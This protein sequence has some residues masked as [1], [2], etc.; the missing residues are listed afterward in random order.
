MIHTLLSEYFKEY[1]FAFACLPSPELGG[2]CVIGAAH[3]IST[4]EELWSKHNRQ[5]TSLFGLNYQHLH[6][7]H[8]IHQL[9]HPFIKP[10]SSFGILPELIKEVHLA[11]QKVNQYTY[12]TYSQESPPEKYNN[13]IETIK[14]EIQAGEY[15]EINFCNEWIGDADFQD[16]VQTFLDLYPKANVPYSCLVKLDKHWLLCFSPEQFLNK[17]GNILQTQPIKGTRRTSGDK[18]EQEKLINSLR[19]SKKDLAENVMIVDLMRNDLARIA[20]PR[21]V[22]VPKLF[23]IISF[24]SV[25]QMIS[26]IQCTLPDNLSLSEIHKNLFPMGSMTGAPKTRVMKA[27]QQLETHDRGLFSGTIGLLEPNNDFVSNVVIRSIQYH[28]EYKKASIWAGG[29]ITF[30]SDLVEEWNECLTKASL[31]LPYLKNPI[32]Q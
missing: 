19:S 13:I 1:P 15:Y 25:I 29:A 21:S 8:Q 31:L 5:S 27:I 14:A 18:S 7:K 10:P 4:A 23:D 16:P 30:Q 32:L 2:K 22:Y 11:P 26:T 6:Q 17:S 3:Q 28:S 24:G 12:P 9:Q 20:I